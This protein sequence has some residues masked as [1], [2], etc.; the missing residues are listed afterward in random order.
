MKR[1]V[2]VESDQGVE[3]VTHTAGRNVN[4]EIRPRAC[5]RLARPRDKIYVSKKENRSSNFVNQN[6]VLIFES[7]DKLNSLSFD[8]SNGR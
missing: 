6:A 3:C 1:A 8:H 4:R 2:R 7:W 5:D